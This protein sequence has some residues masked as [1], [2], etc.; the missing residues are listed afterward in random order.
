MSCSNSATTSGVRVRR[1]WPMACRMSSVATCWAPFSNTTRSN[2]SCAVRRAANS[3]SA[4][5]NSRDRGHVELT[6]RDRGEVAV[7]DRLPRRRVR[8]PDGDDVVEPAVPQERAVQGA[9]RVRGTDQQPLILLPERRDELE[10]LV[11]D[12]LRG[13]DRTWLARPSDL[14]HLVDEQHYLV[15]L[16]DQG[17]RLPQ[18]GG[19]PGRGLAGQPRREQFHERPP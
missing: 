12:T 8:R 6:M 10:H 5:V 14:L 9:H 18:G 16:G 1:V 11:R 3:M 2:T 17:E 15:Q 19:Q 7:P 13:R 4:G